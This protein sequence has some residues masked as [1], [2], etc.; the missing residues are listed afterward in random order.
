MHAGSPDRANRR[1]ASSLAVIIAGCL[2]T[3]LAANLILVPAL[4]GQAQVQPTAGPVGSP[5]GV[6]REQIHWIP[7]VD[8]AGSQHLLQAR[9]C[10]PP[11][12]MPARTV[13]IAHGT[14]PNNRNAKPGR[15]EGE[16]MRWFL[17][18]GFIVV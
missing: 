16:A 12:E 2:V 14:F 10:R 9:I 8:A 3:I 18:R 17:D 5:E 1:R 13:V 11:G 15:C 6:W 4:V 7:M